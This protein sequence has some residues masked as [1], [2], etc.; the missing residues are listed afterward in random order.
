WAQARKPPAA[1]V[2]ASARYVLAATQLHA[3]ELD[4]A[5]NTIE[6][7]LDQDRKQHLTDTWPMY[8][9]GARI[10]LAQGKA[11]QALA[12]ADEGLKRAG[13]ALPPEHHR[14]GAL[15]S[16]R[17]GAQAPLRRCPGRGEQPA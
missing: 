17:R 6:A 12:L 2:L 14:L 7:V 11:E 9:L 1:A 13:P 8:A 15:R 5:R 16:A 3:G 4:A 10:A